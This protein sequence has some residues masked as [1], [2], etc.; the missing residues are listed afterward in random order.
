MSPKYHNFTFSCY[1]VAL[2][3]LLPLNFFYSS[4]IEASEVPSTPIA[5]LLVAQPVSK[6]VSSVRVSHVNSADIQGPSLL[7]CIGFSATVRPGRGSP[8]SCLDLESEGALGLSVEDLLGER[9]P[10]L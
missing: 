4:C 3:Q 1:L 8:I 2:S 7:T 6:H 10:R 9:L 5:M